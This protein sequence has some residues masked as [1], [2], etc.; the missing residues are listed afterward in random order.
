MKL[1]EMGSEKFNRNS[2]YENVTD[3]SSD[4]GNPIRLPFWIFLL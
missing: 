1:N 4:K 3:T 2:K